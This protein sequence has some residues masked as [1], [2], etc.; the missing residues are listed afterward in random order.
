MGPVLGWGS[1]PLRPF[2]DFCPLRVL[3]PSPLA[4]SRSGPSQESDTQG[5]FKFHTAQGMP[6]L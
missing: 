6:R 2:P 4:A 5:K 1:L 3:P